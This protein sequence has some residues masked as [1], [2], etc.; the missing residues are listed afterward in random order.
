MYIK[1]FNCHIGTTICFWLFGFPGWYQLALG[2][3]TADRARP[4]SFSSS[5]R[6]SDGGRR[7]FARVVLRLLDRHRD[8]RLFQAWANLIGLGEN[9]HGV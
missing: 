5:V 6:Y 4:S 8:Q 7:S 3:G 1:D 9:K 2:H